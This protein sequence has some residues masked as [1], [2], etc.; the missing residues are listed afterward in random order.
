VPG[1]T[2]LMEAVEADQQ[3]AVETLLQCSSESDHECQTGQDPHTSNAPYFA[4]HT[5][6]YC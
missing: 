6:I 4:P 1:K 3:I 5:A 2:A